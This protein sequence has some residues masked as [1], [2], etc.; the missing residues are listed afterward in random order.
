[1]FP[2]IKL[3]SI[4]KNAIINQVIFQKKSDKQ[5]NINQI[6][7]GTTLFNN[8]CSN[9]T[10]EH[11]ITALQQQLHSTYKILQVSNKLVKRL[12]GGMVDM[13][14]KRLFVIIESIVFF[15]HWIFFKFMNNLNVIHLIALHFKL[16]C[17]NFVS[18]IYIELTHD[19][20]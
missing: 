20:N 11:N 14:L 1:M 9:W 6:E 8:K 10:N 17:V 13:P 2:I 18:K 15:F 5:D 4:N 3:H 19:R 12:I 16:H 7:I